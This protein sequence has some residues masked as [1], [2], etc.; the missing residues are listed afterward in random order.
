MMERNNGKIIAIVALVVAV[1]GLSLGF[2]AFSTSLTIDTTAN[3]NTGN[4]NWN[5]G[6]SANGTSIADVST[7]TTLNGAAS[8]VLNV[9]KYTLS[10]ATNATLNFSTAKSVSYT[11]SIKNAGNITAYLDKV[12]F[13]SVSYTCT[14][15]AAG[16][17]TVIEGTASAGTSSTGG[18]TS[19]ISNADCA[20]MFS[21]TLSIDSTNY[22][23]TQT[24]IT[25]KSIAAGASVPVVLTVAYK[26]DADANA[27][28]DTL[29]G[30]IIVSIGT[31]GVDYKSV[32]NN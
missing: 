32:A 28:A 11:L 3:V 15:A 23:T 31:I 22:T 9:T 20:K 1:I 5:V 21:V 13:D 24:G 19:T 30:D 17:S 4:T 27:V 7:P 6:F 25:G 2:A 16:T 18:N 29:D 10:Q 12:D 8:G 14:N 26:D